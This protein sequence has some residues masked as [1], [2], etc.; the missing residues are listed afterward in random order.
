MPAKVWKTN[1][2][3]RV[4][5]LSRE[6]Q[7]SR[8]ENNKHLNHFPSSLVTVVAQTRAETRAGA[9][10]NPRSERATRI[11]RNNSSGQ[12][13]GLQNPQFLPKGSRNTKAAKL[14]TNDAH[15]MAERLEK[16]GGDLRI[17]G[18]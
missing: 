14:M 1:N 12:G 15:L 13:L 18:D 17:G 6:Q 16:C 10:R 4:P 9:E 11:T 3:N 8:L 5:N 7:N 2:Y